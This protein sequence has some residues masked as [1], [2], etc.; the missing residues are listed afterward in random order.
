MDSFKE[1]HKSYFKDKLIE[2]ER[3][4]HLPEISATLH[5]MSRDMLKMKAQIY[6]LKQ[7]NEVNEAVRTWLSANVSYEFTVRNSVQQW[8]ASRTLAS[9]MIALKQPQTVSFFLGKTQLS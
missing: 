6:S 3:L 2:N 8:V 1:Q 7:I 9:L 4:S 5:A